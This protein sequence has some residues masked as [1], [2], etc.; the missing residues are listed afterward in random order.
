[1][2]LRKVISRRIR[3]EG[4]GL[5]V[6]A[7]VNAAVAGSIDESDRQHVSVSSNQHIVQRGSSRRRKEDT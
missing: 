5:N 7:D 6:V 1:M 2:K 3:H 4:P